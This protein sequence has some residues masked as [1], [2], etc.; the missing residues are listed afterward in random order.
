MG[1]GAVEWSWGSVQGGDG[2]DRRRVLGPRPSSPGEQG[3]SKM[4]REDGSCCCWLARAS[5]LTDGERDGQVTFGGVMFKRI[6][7]C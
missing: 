5:V 2:G 7:M 6:K 4:R 1:T 3:G